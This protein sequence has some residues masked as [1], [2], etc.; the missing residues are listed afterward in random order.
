MLRLSHLKRIYPRATRTAPRSTTAACLKLKEFLKTQYCGESPF[1]NS[2]DDGCDT[3]GR[4]THVSTTKIEADY[5][6][7]QNQADGTWQCQQKGNPSP[8]IRKILI[9]KMRRVGMPAE[10][11]TDVHFNVL[12]SS[13]S[14]VSLASAGYDHKHGD[15]IDL[16]EVIV[17]IDT[18]GQGHLIH[19]L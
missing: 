8:E 4:K 18:T 1:G 12:S 2:P 13:G 10:V 9:E 5:S 6:C 14:S 17:A 19:R 3:R 11:E 15:D 7:E 16:C